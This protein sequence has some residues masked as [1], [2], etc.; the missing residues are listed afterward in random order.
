MPRNYEEFVYEELR[1][2]I[3]VA[4]VSF[5]INLLNELPEEKREL[6]KKFIK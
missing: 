4:D 1:R 5:I 3:P 2:D 6:I